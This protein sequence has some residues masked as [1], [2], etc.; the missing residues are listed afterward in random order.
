MSTLL[1]KYRQESSLVG[2]ITS[3]LVT[4]ASQSEPVPDVRSSVALPFAHL[5]TGDENER[6]LMEHTTG[7]S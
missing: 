4:V 6:G 7:K 1:Y 5:T 3:A 2:Y